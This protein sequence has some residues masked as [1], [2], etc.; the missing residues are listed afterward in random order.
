MNRIFSAL[1]A[2]AAGF[3]VLCA[4]GI[5]QLERLAWKQELIAAIDGKL[6]RE[7]V[8]LETVELAPGAEFTKV[9]A[10]GTYVPQSNRFLITALAGGGGW[11]VVTPMLLPGN[12]VILV[13]RGVIPATEQAAFAAEAVPGEPQTVTGILRLTR[14]RPGLF[15]P[16]NSPATNT[17][18]WWDVPAMLASVKLPEGSKSIEAVLQLIPA[19]GAQSGLPQPQPPAAKLTNNHLQYALT[20]FAFAVIL[21]IVTALFVRGQMKKTGA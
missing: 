9:T 16:K 14:D 7:A 13:D 12:R 17:W 8:P 11:Q 18:Y 21:A 10:I 1:L 2:A 6:A 4:L 20:W 5:W 3:A 15:T 19:P